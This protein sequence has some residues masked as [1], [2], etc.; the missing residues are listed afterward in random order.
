MIRSACLMAVAASMLWAA[1]PAP[2][3]LTDQEKRDGWVLLFDGKTMQG[4]DDP[5]AKTPPG[6]AWTIDDECLKA[7]PHPRITE[8][9][10]STQFTAISS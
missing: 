6:D 5:R 3:T 1:G 8:N 7:N 9:L 4:W 2:N 10:F